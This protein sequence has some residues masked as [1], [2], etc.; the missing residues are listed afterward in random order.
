MSGDKEW[1]EDED[2]PIVTLFPCPVRGS[3]YVRR[4]CQLLL[5]YYTHRGLEVPH[6]LTRDREGGMAESRVDQVGS[7]QISP[8]DREWDLEGNE[9]GGLSTETL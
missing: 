2:D 8:E 4:R 9:E 7:N 3:A 5:R 1:V 6:R